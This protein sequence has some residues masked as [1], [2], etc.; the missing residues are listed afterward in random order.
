MRVVAGEGASGSGPSPRWAAADPGEVAGEFGVDPDRGLPAEEVQRRCQEQGE[1]RIERIDHASTWRLFTEQFRN[2]LIGL[3]FAAA[4]VAGVVGHLRDAVLIGAVLVANALIGFVQER[5]AQTSMEA[6]QAT[7]TFTAEV[8][9]DGERRAVDAIEL[10]PGDI[11][12]VESGG[13][14]PADGR[15]VEARNLAVDESSLTGESTPVDK[16]VEPVR[17]DVPLAERVSELFMG[18]SLTRGTGRMIVTRTG[19]NTEMGRVSAE[20]HDAEGRRSPLE[21]QVGTLATRLAAIALVAASAVVGVAMLRGDT[22]GEALIDGVVLAVASIP[23]GLPA[24]VTITLALGMRAMARR[25]AVVRDLHAIHTLGATTVICTDKTGTLTLNQMTVRVVEAHGTR[26]EVS[27]GGYGTEGAITVSGGD[28][29]DRLPRSA[30]EVGVLCNDASVDGDQV[31]G[32]PTEA[33]LVVLARKA[34]VVT[35]ELHR[36]LPRVAEVPFSSDRRYMATFHQGEGGT[37]LLVKGAPMVVLDRCATV[38][39]TAGDDGGVAGL[40]RERRHRIE[41]QVEDLTRDGLRVLALAR[42]RCDP[43]PENADEDRLAEEVRDLRLEA[44]V[45]MEDPPRPEAAAAVAEA[46]GAGIKVTMVTGDHALTAASI[47]ED[48]GIVG[49]AVEGSDLDRLDDEQLAAR[50]GDIG[51]LARVDPQ[52]KVRVVDAFRAAGHVVAMTGDGVND[53]AALVRADVG[54][55]MGRRGTEVAKEAGDIVLTDDRLETI[56]RAIRRGRTIFDN[57]VTF[58]TFNLATNLGALIAILF[59]RIVGMPTPFT[60]LQV[61]WVNLIMDGPPAMALGA[62]PPGPDVMRR[63]PR[64]PEARILTRG[65][66][67]TLLALGGWM[68]TATLL[69]LAWARDDGDAQATTTAFTTFVLLQVVNALNVRTGRHSVFSPR[70]A[71]NPALWGALAVVTVLQ[72]AVVQIEPLAGLI[73]AEPLPWSHWA[74]AVGAA[75]SLLALSELVRAV[76]RGRPA[77]ISRRGHTPFDRTGTSGAATRSV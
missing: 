29:P 41:Q 21:E 70:A 47:A 16:Q 8:Y 14:V 44:L 24:I 55:A 60:P 35:D 61:L 23:E 28:G 45:G 69:A 52:H 54:V 25:N 10:V 12:L 11:V 62:D 30:L 63:P 27:G 13:R 75:L 40:D 9:R 15:L 22:L 50:I 17:G 34:G 65:R 64:D 19:M 2:P 18:T 39:A 66:I 49:D 58:V 31:Q 46:L 32:D 20:M 43:P 4:A 3:L 76:L 68:A 56:V 67:V 72:V 51:V 38:A 7:L 57:I 33:A 71:T 48:L 42:R 53:A 73:G 5:R 1:N 59:A 36:D 6:L 77:R 26:F 74:V 37:H